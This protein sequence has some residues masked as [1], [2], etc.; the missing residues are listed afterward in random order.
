MTER[1]EVAVRAAT[2]KDVDALDDLQ[3]EIY[4]EGVAFVGDGAEVRLRL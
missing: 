4:R 1:P 3:R 2:V